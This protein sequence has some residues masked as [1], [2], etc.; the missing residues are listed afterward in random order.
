LV[1]TKEAAMTTIERALQS[2]ILRAG[3]TTLGLDRHEG[4]AVMV[5]KF[6][7]WSRRPMERPLSDLSEVSVDANVDRASGVELCR[8]MLV[9]RDGSAWALP[10]TD[11]R[12]ATESAAAIRDF[13]GIAEN[14]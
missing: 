2:L 8:T 3:S 5:R 4:K 10:L 11:R 13:L 7:F 12:D 1:F 6:L 9:M 14:G